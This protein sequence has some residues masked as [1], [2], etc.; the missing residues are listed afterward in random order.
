EPYCPLMTIRPAILTCP[1]GAK[2]AIIGQ[3]ERHG[4]AHTMNGRRSRLGLLLVLLVA[5]T[6]CSLADSDEPVPTVA[7]LDTL[8]T[9]IFLTEHA[10]PAGYQLVNFDP[11]DAR[12]SERQ[13]WRY[14]VTGRVEG[15]FDSTGE[16][17]NGQVALSVRV[18]ELG[19]AR[20]GAPDGEGWRSLVTAGV[21]GTFDATGEAANGQL[22]LAAPVDGLGEARRVVLRVEGGALSPDDD[23]R[24]LEGVRLGN[25]YYIVDT[26][27]VCSAGG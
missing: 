18:D 21:E 11:I 10:P 9:A 15:T 20:R 24:R 14:L 4:A 25:D 5:L 22:G 12:L 27:G 23:P 1:H 7:R 8:P 6:A 26:N 3:V 2:T 17:A 19:E 13:G 16:S